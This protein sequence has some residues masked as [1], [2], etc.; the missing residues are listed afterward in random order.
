M[1]KNWVLW[2]AAALLVCL[3]PGMTREA[4]AETGVVGEIIK[5][6]CRACKKYTQVQIV[7]HYAKG[8]GFQVS[9]EY[10]WTDFKCLS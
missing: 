10:H 5:R 3:L 2:L 1:K 4:S 8:D 9:E 6:T 7:R